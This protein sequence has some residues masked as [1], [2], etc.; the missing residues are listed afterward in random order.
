MFHIFYHRELALF[1][2][3]RG[4]K[5][6]HGGERDAFNGACFEWFRVRDDILTGLEVMWFLE[7]HRERDRDSLMN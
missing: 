7:C 1:S 6:S 5:E 3:L 2:G 4:L